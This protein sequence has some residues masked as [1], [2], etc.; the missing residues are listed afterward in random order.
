MAISFNLQT[1]PYHSACQ[2]NRYDL[3]SLHAIKL[4]VILDS[5]LL[6]LLLAH[7][8]P[9]CNNMTNGE[10]A[11]FSWYPSKGPHIERPWSNIR[12]AYDPRLTPQLQR[13]YTVVKLV[14]C[15]PGTS[16]VKRSKIRYLIQRWLRESDS[17]PISEVAAAWHELMIPQR[18]MR[19][20][21][22]HTS[23]QLDP[24]SSPQPQTYHRPNR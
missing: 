11:F 2:A 12:Y 9:H 10:F 8:P 5:H 15:M 18:T 1:S 4:H 16:K 24:R 23:E 6:S 19:P 22:A 13:A 21:I 7:Q 3:V 14:S 17:W 20:S